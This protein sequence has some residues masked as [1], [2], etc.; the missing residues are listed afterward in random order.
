[1]RQRWFGSSRNTVG[2]GLFAH[3]RSSPGV[4]V[5]R[6]YGAASTF[7]RELAVR[8]PLSATYRYEITSVEA[9]DVYFCVNFGVCDAFTIQ[10]LK[11]Q[12]SMS[13]LAISLNVDR[14]NAPLSPTKG[15]RLRAELE[16]ASQFTASDF[17]YNR[18]AIDLAAYLP[19]P[20]RRSVGAAHLQAGW[21]RPLAGTAKAVGLGDLGDAL[22]STRILHPRKRFYAGGSQSVR[23]FGENQLGPRV[24]TIAPDKLRGRAIAGV[25]TTWLC[26]P[27]VDITQCDPSAMQLGDRDFQV[28][29]LGGTTL[30]A[31]SIELRVP[32][33]RSLVAAVF[34]DGAILGEGTLGTITKGS[35]ALTP[36]FGVRYESPVGPVRVDLGVRPTLRRALPVITQTTDSAGRRVL[37]SLSP[38]NGCSQGSTVGCRTFPDPA[39]KVSFFRALAS[40]LTLHLSIGQAF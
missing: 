10:A 6:G 15:V 36:G 30:L 24:L 37:V 25:D 21:V 5:D 39:E 27:T 16:H 23:G 31:G 1:V 4:F 29:P 19:L 35:G 13:P 18:A 20:F 7:T 32:V 40:R 9:G 8:T 22:E 14:S 17:R 34:V 2:A 12:Q 11:G 33:W 3:R 38:E 26:A 28:R